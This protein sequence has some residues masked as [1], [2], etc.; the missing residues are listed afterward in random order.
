[1]DE[2]II[3]AVGKCR[4]VIRDGRVVDVGMPRIS[5]CPLARRFACPVDEI[6][7]E[8]VRDNVQNRID[9][10]GMC[11]PLRELTSEEI[12]V[13]FGASEVISTS[14]KSRFIDAAVIACDGAGTVVVTRPD[15]AQGIGGRM[16]GLIR[17]TPI[18]EVINRIIEGGGIVADPLN[19]SLDPLAGVLAAKNAGHEHLVVTIHDPEDAKR[20]REHDPDAIIIAVHTTGYSAGDA[21]MV[22]QYADIVTACASGTVREI[23]GPYAV[24]QAGSSV[25][26]YVLTPAGKHLILLRMAAIDYPLFTTHADLPVSGERCPKPLV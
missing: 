11:T 19:A 18:P 17:T 20:V 14:L 7:P 10:F 26:V 6:T 2:H 22:R 21:E 13:G 25:P 24:L 16:S 12:F 23:C 15:M 5:S 8:A 9:S 3:E 1:M 4:I